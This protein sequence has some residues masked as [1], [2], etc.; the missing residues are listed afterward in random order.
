MEID[1]RMTAVTVRNLT[2]AFGPS[3]VLRG[4]DLAVPE[5]SV[6]AILGPSGCG[7]TTLLRLVAGFDGPDS[8]EILLGERMVSGNGSFV[9]PQ[10]RAVGYVPQEGA[11]FP[12]LDIADNITF[13]LKG[14][15][16]RSGHRV[17]ELLA[18]G[19]AAGAL[20]TEKAG[21]YD[22]Q[23]T[24]SEALRLVGSGGRTTG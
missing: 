17:E 9:A 15:E 10:H 11:L 16:R 6:T 5:E 18:Y 13:G 3:K 21:G 4:I 1:A 8:G 22:G 14:R 19:C 20:S 2:K 7:K 23:P 24:R 12:H